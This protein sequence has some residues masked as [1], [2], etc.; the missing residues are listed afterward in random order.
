MLRGADG[1]TLAAVRAISGVVASEGYAEGRV[2]R[3]RFDFGRVV[4]ALSEFGLRQG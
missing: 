3:E 4:S 1:L 2:S